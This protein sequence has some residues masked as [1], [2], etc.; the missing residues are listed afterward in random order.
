[1]PQEGSAEKTGS[2]PP[3]MH[4]GLNRLSERGFRGEYVRNFE[5]S[6]DSARKD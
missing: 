3:P 1:V 5:N 6:R 4:V 2:L